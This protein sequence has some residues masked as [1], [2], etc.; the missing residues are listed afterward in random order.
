MKKPRLQWGVLF[1]PVPWGFMGHKEQAD[2]RLRVWRQLRE[3]LRKMKGTRPKQS[4]LTSDND[5]SKTAETG[6]SSTIWS[7]GLMTMRL[8]ALVHFC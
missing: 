6:L 5:L 7:M 4:T 1:T 2:I 8:M 3:R